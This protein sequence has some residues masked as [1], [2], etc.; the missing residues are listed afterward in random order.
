MSPALRSIRPELLVACFLVIATPS[1]AAWESVEGVI[2]GRL[3]MGGRPLMGA[4]ITGCADRGYFFGRQPCMSPFETRTDA[5]GRFTFKQFT[6]V[7]PPTRREIKANPGYAVFDPGWGYGFRVDYEGMA[8]EAFSTGMGYGR[9]HVR[10]ECDFGAFL[11]AMK[12]SGV[13]PVAI[14]GNM[15]FIECEYHEKLIELPRE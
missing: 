10:V 7:T 6:G 8:A 5:E 1:F 11:E 4:Q 3:L 2:E 9:T 12:K 13:R 15:P 14:P